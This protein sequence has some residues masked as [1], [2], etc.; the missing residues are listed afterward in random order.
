MRQILFIMDQ[1]K[2][3]LFFS[4]APSNACHRVVFVVL[5][6]AEKERRDGIRH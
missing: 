3:Q 5:N 2:F 4:F 6:D 1:A